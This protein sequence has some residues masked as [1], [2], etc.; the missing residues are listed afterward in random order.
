LPFDEL[1]ETKLGSIIDGETRRAG[2]E[3]ASFGIKWILV[4]GDSSGSDGENPAVAWRNV[5]AGQLDLL[6]LSSSTG[7][8]TFVT[9]VVP[10]G[11]ALTSG[12]DSWARTGWT[13]EGA[14][15]EGRRVFVAEN[16]DPGWGPPPRATVGSMNEVA[17]DT[18][19]VVYAPNQGRRSQA[20]A[21]LAGILLLGS[22][23]VVGKRLQ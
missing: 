18:G 16:A 23:V 14:P 6:P 5:F 20:L 22:M 17:A 4:M 19:V 12:Q 2:G 15:D 9:D 8:A 3:L 1:L 21:V 11:R 13:Y 10:V 7:N